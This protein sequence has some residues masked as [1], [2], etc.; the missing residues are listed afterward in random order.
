MEFYIIDLR[1]RQGIK[2]YE[3]TNQPNAVHYANGILHPSG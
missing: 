3:K 2:T 1:K